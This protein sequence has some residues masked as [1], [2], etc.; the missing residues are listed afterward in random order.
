MRGHHCTP[1][2][3]MSFSSR[4]APERERFFGAIPAEQLPG[5]STD[6]RAKTSFGPKCPVLADSLS[7]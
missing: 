3:R 1:S 2:S 4:A 6:A 7:R 5:M